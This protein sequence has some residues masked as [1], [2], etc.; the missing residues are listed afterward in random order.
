MKKAPLLTLSAILLT[1]SACG[2]T[3]QMVEGHQFKHAF[4]GLRM[5]SSD[6]PSL[7]MKRPGAPN[8]SHYKHFIIDPVRVDY[9]DPD[10]QELDIEDVQRMRTYF[11]SALVAE[12]RDGGYAV[13]TRSGPNTMRISPIITGMPASG[14][15][16]VTNVAGI[17]ATSLVG[18]PGVFSINVGEV[19]V[20]T[21]FINAQYNRIDA[22]VVDRSKGS[23]LMNSKPWSTWADVE[24][25]FDNWAEGIRE[26]LD[27]AHRR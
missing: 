5:D 21:A 12:L 20:E 3:S 2:P 7:V 25:A 27:K 23:H 14:G 10:M 4:K 16:G 17:V 26:A 22:I 11:H 18:A 8:L 6:A 1:L 13:G 24:G 15:G 19:T 9:N